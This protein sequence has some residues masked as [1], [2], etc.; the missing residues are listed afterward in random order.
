MLYDH[1]VIFSRNRIFIRAGERT[2][3][4]GAVKG[5]AIAVSLPLYVRHIIAMSLYI[6]ILY[7]TIHQNSFERCAVIKQFLHNTHRPT[8]FSHSIYV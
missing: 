5:M 1:G 3:S 8:Y 2:Q 4:V 7:T 6:Y